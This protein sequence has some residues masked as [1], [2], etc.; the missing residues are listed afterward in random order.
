MSEYILVILSVY[1]HP[2]VFG[3]I[4]GKKDVDPNKPYGKIYYSKSPE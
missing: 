2:M 4:R 1:D 3:W